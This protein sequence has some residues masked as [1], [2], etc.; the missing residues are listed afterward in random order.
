MSA[1][2]V[3]FFAINICILALVPPYIVTF[4]VLYCLRCRRTYIRS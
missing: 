1:I 2:N 4:S 3:I